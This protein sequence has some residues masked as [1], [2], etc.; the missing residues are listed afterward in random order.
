MFPISTSSST[1]NRRAFP[2]SSL[3]LRVRR[4][5]AAS[6]LRITAHGLNMLWC[7]LS[8]ERAE[9]AQAKPVFLCHGTNLFHAL[10]CQVFAQGVILEA[11]FQSQG[12][13]F[14]HAAI[15]FSW[16]KTKV[17]MEINGAWN[18]NH[19]SVNH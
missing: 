1:T 17:K 8:L 4:A 11:S 2:I 7:D 16:R 3:Q 6:S 14:S 9:P 10:S 18:I 13:R 5:Q 15:G 19:S 12:N